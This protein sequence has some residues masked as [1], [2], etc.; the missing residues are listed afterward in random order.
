[1]PEQAFRN[2]SSLKAG[3]L[4]LGLLFL[5][6]LFLRFEL[7]GRTEADFPELELRFSERLALVAFHH[8]SLS[9]GRQQD[10]LTLAEA[11]ETDPIIRAVLAQRE[12]D[13]EQRADLSGWFSR[14]AEYQVKPTENLALE[15]RE[16]A[17][18]DANRLKGCTLVFLGLFGFSFGCLLA[19]KAR[20]QSPKLPS[21]TSP[22]AIWGVFLAWACFTFFGTSLLI[23]PLQGVLDKFWLLLFGQGVS[24]GV[25][26]VLLN[27][28]GLGPINLQFSSFSWGW[29]G[30]G[31]LLAVAA[32]LLANLVS[33]K[34]L[35]LPP[36]SSNPILRL[37]SEATVGELLVLA[38]LV[39]LVGPF[40]EELIFRSW[41]LGG[42]TRRWSPWAALLVSSA[43]FAVFHADLLS[44]LALTALGLVFGWLYL[45]SGSLA[46]PI[47]VH[48]MWNA[49]TFTLLMAGLP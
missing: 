38:G 43:V 31:Y 48:S 44:T 49:T 42:L 46:V 23:Y 10:L 8:D 25:L 6:G 19:G 22:W 24:Y 9:P 21:Q 20:I 5:F 35:G 14:M 12:L 41:L 29:V 45:R 7:A 47:L 11:L 34:L 2:N 37:F 1:M 26:W 28:G 17:Q 33:S 3:V 4:W 36:R 39:I 13:S 18:H 27:R 16:Q 40:F 30:R 32:V 15:L